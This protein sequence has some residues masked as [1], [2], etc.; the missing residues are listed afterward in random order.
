MVP[1]DFSKTE[2]G[3]EDGP[4]SSTHPQGVSQKVQAP[5]TSASKLANES[6]SRKAWVLFKELLQSWALGPLSAYRPFQILF[7]VWQSPAR[8]VSESLT[9]FQSQG[10]GEHVS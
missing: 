4:T 6:L 2:G 9:G 1:I 5:Q 8:L 10:F 7:S 3:Q